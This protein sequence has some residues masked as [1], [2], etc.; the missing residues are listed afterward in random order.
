MPIE[1]KPGMI[2]S[3]R[4]ALQ[5]YFS[6][7]R[8]QRR[9]VR[10]SQ[11]EGVHTAQEWL[12][13]LKGQA[14]FDFYA[15]QTRKHWA[16]VAIVGFFILIFAAPFSI[17]LLFESEFRFFHPVITFAL[18]ALPIL[19]LGSLILYYYLKFKDVPN[20]LREFVVP[21]LYILQEETH[22]EELIRLQL[23]FRPKARKDNQIKQYQNYKR[24]IL[25]Q[26]V[27][28][29]WIALA[30][31]GGGIAVTGRHEWLTLAMISFWVLLALTFASNFIFGKYP[32]LFFTWHTAEWFDIQT[33]LLDGTLIHL[34]IQDDVEKRKITRKKSGRSG[35]TKIK[36]KTKYKIRTNYWVR[37]GLPNKHY[38]A[39]PHPKSTTQMGDLKVKIK[40]GEKRQ[41][42]QFKAREKHK[43]IHYAPSIELVLSLVSQAYKKVKKIA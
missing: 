40:R 19:S 33:R 5:T 27:V 1:S 17:P 9:A 39:N 6:L 11:L 28:Y 12:G 18:I 23:D 37:V 43:D 14:R 10:R 35:K 36:T 7:N 22:P 29:G 20:W 26:I 13:L 38:E 30:L 21:L 2:S 15:D 31:L 3:L 41:V 34:R 42:H 24:S 32:R 25:S 8:E 4:L 16:T